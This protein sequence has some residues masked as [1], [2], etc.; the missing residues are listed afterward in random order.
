MNYENTLYHSPWERLNFPKM[1]VQI[2]LSLE[3]LKHLSIDM[4]KKATISIFS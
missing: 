2:N 3:Y 4:I 1:F